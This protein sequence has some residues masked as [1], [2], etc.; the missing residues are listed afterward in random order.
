[1]DVIILK[2]LELNLKGNL[3]EK[4]VIAEIHLDDGTCF[5]T[6]SFDTI[7]AG[8]AINFETKT[9]PPALVFVSINHIHR[10]SITGARIKKMGFDIQ[11]NISSEQSSSSK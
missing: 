5:E 11:K 7:E 3:Q 1:M 8:N 2:A 10:I 4:D 6:L 9:N